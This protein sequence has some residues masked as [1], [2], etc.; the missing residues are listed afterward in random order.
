MDEHIEIQTVM[1]K[2]QRQLAVGSEADFP[3]DLVATYMAKHAE[4]IFEPKR[5]LTS[6][7]WLKS[8]REP[9]QRFEYYKQGKGNI[10]WLS[11]AKN[12]VYLFACDKSFTKDQLKQYRKYAQA[13]FM[14]VKDVEIIRAGQEIPG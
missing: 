6:G 1:T 7:D 5:I 3:D 8:Y 14:G 13:F 10:K 12:K 4:E 2:K 11:P 9:D